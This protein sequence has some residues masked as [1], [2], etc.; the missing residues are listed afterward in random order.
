MFLL[1]FS[2]AHF[3][4]AQV[5]DVT[6]H[7]KNSA[8][9]SMAYASVL[10]LK[11]TDSTMV[12]GVSTDENGAFLIDDVAPDIYFLQA[13]YI[14]KKSAF[15]PIDISKDVNIGAIILEEDIEQLEEVAVS[16]KN[17]TIKRKADRLIFN[18]E[19]TVVSQ[20][21]SWDLLKRTPGVIVAQ[22][23]IK[24]R[25]QAATIYLNNRKLQL[26]S[27]EVKNLLE[28]FSGVNIKSIEVIHNPPS[29]YEAEGGAILNIITSK[30]IIPGYKGSINGTI[31]QAIFP[32]YTIGTSHYYK[33]KK[34]NVFT[35]YS[36]NPSKELKKD[37][38]GINFING[39]DTNFAVWDTKFSR[40]TRSL[41]Q[42]ASV[43]LDYDFDEKNSLN[44]TSNLSF[45]PN[46]G[47]NNA[48]LTKMF[49][50]Q[51]VLDS[52]LQTK[53]TLKNDNINFGTELTFKHKLNREGASINF[54]GHITKFKETQNQAVFSNY[55]DATDV[56]I[57]GF[58]FSTDTHQK[59]DI[60]IGQI[61]Y[62][63]P[64][65]SL[66]FNSGVKFSSISSKSGIDFFNVNGNVSVLNNTLSDIFEYNENISAGYVSALKDWKKWSLKLGLRGEHTAVIGKS[67]S[68]PTE[69]NQSYFELFPTIFILYR[70]SVNHSI[71]LDYSRKLTRPRYEELNPFSY[72]LNENNFN[73]GNPN[74]TPSFS[75]NFNINYTLKDTYYFDVYYRDNGNFISTL[76]FQDN[77]N[78]TIRELKQ[79]VLA[80][81]SYGVDF[82]YSKP[83]SKNWY[84]YSYNSIFSEKE[85]FLAV[86]SNNQKVTNEI[87]GFYGAVT[88]YLTLSKDE[89]FTGE[90]GLVYLSKFM[91]GSYV[92]SSTTNLTFGVRKT[93]WN[94]SA[95]VSLIAE[96]LLD[97]ANTTLTSKYLNQ[98]NFRFSRP[99]TQFIRFG[100][101]YNFGNYKLL[102]NKRELEKI[103][104]ERLN[105]E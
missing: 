93:L 69:N 90:L 41:A 37:D 103:E 87:K 7:V 26:S 81:E 25:N 70:P 43:I 28:G 52:S 59:I 20:G 44:I 105:K 63:T 2:S 57:R 78:K 101:T 1:Y 5:Y 38:S 80:S 8:N 83:V 102:D 56:F 53:S 49:N 30:M 42:N 36:I 6:G 24:I 72:F 29:E 32:K 79:N 17:P 99:E 86:E 47:Y 16:S 19:N 18:V 40:T 85:T 48:L 104:L 64:F 76:V 88:N 51:Q 61:D 33:T 50:A 35:N 31:T 100:F 71:S 15:L 14:N 74:L 3:L 75:H 23:Q 95:V 10:L 9:E 97:K 65:K 66:T 84:V 68:N 58:D 82:T 89:T 11:M 21:N 12:S 92:F 54:S 62:S 22:D 27:N 46:K 91:Q 60:L 13:S 67:A 77:E 96:N 73:T 94:K 34:I 98:D 4:A 55:F 39:T 45:S